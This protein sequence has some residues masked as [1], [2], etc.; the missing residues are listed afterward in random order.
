MQGLMQPTPLTLDTVFNRAESLWSTKTL[1]TSTPAGLER[2]DYRTWSD[3]TRRL[4]GVLDNLGISPDGRVATFAWNNT[5]HLELYFAAPCSG[6]VLHTLNIRL[7]ADQLVYIANHAGDEVVFV[8]RSLL[9]ILWPLIDDFKTVRHVVVM[10]DTGKGG[11]DIP[12]DPRISDYEE[13]LAAADAHSFSVVKDENVAASMCYTS[14]TTGDPKGVVYSHRSVVLHTMAAM[15]TD[16][17]AISEADVIVPVVPMFHANAW[18]LCQAGVMAGSTIVFPGA[19]LS[20]EAV[21]SLITGEKVTVAAGVP[22]IWMGAR[23]LLAGREHQLRVVLCGG[24]A[25]PKALAEA[26]RTEIGVPILQ[27]CGMTETSPLASVARVRS[28]RAAHC[29]DAELADVR[30]TQGIPVPGV[31]LRIADPSTGEELPWDD[32]MS[33]EVQVRG[34]WIAREYYNDPRGDSSFT[35]DGWLKTGDVAAVSPDGYIRLV[36]RTKDLIKSGGEWISSVELE[37]HLMAH[38]SVAEAAVIAVP[39]DRWMERPMAC[40]VVKQGESLTKEDV[41]EW[42]KPRVAKWWLPDDV[43]FIDAVPKTS[44]GKF[45]KKD[46]RERFSDRKVP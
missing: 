8:D 32:E 10:N 26:Y 37:N 35:P 27:A 13:L 22:T 33:G 19:D 9:P 3:R 17:I 28:E 36:D 40:V 30:A 29:S 20:P 2:I 16:T 23:S 42:L 5:R 24:S 34:P 46:L 14:G 25:V 4:G 38:P 43:E 15:M 39:S 44:V 18:G 45:S 11:P 31:E 7:F 1:V 6:R 12:D 41:L 21:V